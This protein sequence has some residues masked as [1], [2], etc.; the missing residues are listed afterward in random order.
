MY[1]AIAGYSG[2]HESRIRL[3]CRLL[4]VYW[5]ANAHNMPKHAN[6]TKMALC[7]VWLIM[8]RGVDHLWIS[9]LHFAWQ[10][11]DKRGDF[12]GRFVITVWPSNGRL[13]GYSLTITVLRYVRECTNVFAFIIIISASSPPPLMSVADPNCVLASL[14]TLR[15]RS[16][17]RDSQRVNNER[18]IFRNS[19]AQLS[20]HQH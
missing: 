4:R 8:F 7:K 2:A 18:R 10:R 20:H 19:W 12:G 11:M 13:V 5:L 6:F 14:A 16:H 15:N 3:A 1:P 9:N 17:G